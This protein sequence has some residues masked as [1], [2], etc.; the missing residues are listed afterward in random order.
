M[1]IEENKA[2]VRRWLEAW[3]TGDVGPLQDLIAPDYVAHFSSRTVRPE[4]AVEWYRQLISGDRFVYPDF[5]VTTEDLLADG[6]KVIGRWTWGGTNQGESKTPW[7]TIVPPT[8]KKVTSTCITITR[9][10]GG[11]IAEEWWEIDGLSS[12]QQRGAIPTAAPA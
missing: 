12:L 9:I 2:I 11:K 6:D 4:S 3:N 8:G 7:G 1:S 5:H 10:A